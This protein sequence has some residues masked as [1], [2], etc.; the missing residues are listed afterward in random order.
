MSDGIFGHNSGT[1]YNLNTSFH[2]EN[3]FDAW[4]PSSI[5]EQIGAP[6]VSSLSAATSVVTRA[7]GYNPV[8]QAQSASAGTQQVRTNDAAAGLDS[9][10]ASAQST[11]DNLS[12]IAGN[13]QKATTEAQTV[14]AKNLTQAGKNLNMDAGRV[15]TSIAPIVSSSKFSAAAVIAGNIVMPGVGGMISTVIES[16]LDVRREGSRLSK[17]EMESLAD[18]AKRISSAPEEGVLVDQ[19][20]QQA[21]PVEARLNE[22]E[23]DEYIEFVQTRFTDSDDGQKIQSLITE[24]RKNESTARFG[25]ENEHDGQGDKLAAAIDE[26]GD[27]ARKIVESTTQTNFEDIQTAMQ[28]G[29]SLTIAQDTAEGDVERDAQKALSA[30]QVLAQNFEMPEALEIN[31]AQTLPNAAQNAPDE[32]QAPTANQMLYQVKTTLADLSGVKPGFT[33]SFNNEAKG[34]IASLNAEYHIKLEHKN[35]LG[36][37]AVA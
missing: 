19:G 16:A 15:A 35:G 26:G 7:I 12:K 4:K 34:A 14:A 8:A 28:K 27:R 30:D 25:A 2:S 32:P 10:H 22:L 37:G 17:K 6:I 3:I 1:G 29:L 21:N 33:P 24:A 9:T 13:A 18:E 5:V 20:R 36:L 23:S 11:V 31:I